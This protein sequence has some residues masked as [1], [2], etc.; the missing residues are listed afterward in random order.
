VTEKLPHGESA[1]GYARTPLSSIL[2]VL[3]SS[4]AV[5]LSALQRQIIRSEPPAAEQTE[6][7]SGASVAPPRTRRTLFRDDVTFPDLGNASLRYVPDRRD[8]GVVSAFPLHIRAAWRWRRQS[9]SGWRTV[10]LLRLPSA[11]EHVRACKRVRINSVALLRQ[12]IRGRRSH[13]AIRR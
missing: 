8:G 9:A 12:V 7:I 11:D 13:L 2:R 3:P 6:A 1:N 10:R 4:R 5:R